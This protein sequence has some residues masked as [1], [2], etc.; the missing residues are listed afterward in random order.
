MYRRHRRS[1]RRRAMRRRISASSGT[2]RSA[3]TSAS[4]AGGAW[5]RHMMAR[6]ASISGSDSSMPMV[7]PPQRKPSCGSGSRKSSQIDARDAVADRERAD[8]EARPLAA[9]PARIN[10]REHHE[11]H[12]AFERRLVELAR[13]ARQRAAA[14]KHHRP[15]HV[16]RAAP[17]L[18]V[19][20]IGDA[21]EE[22]ADRSRR[23]R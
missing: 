5:R 14:R 1:A 23:R 8:D 13:M 11:Q 4:P 15:R 6:P 9:R 10:S 22:Q 3:I 12:Q 18:A 17:Q 7:S 16:G 21:A 2:L 19:D 20:E